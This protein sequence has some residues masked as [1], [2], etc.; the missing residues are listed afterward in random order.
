[1]EATPLMYA[2][3]NITKS[4]KDE[5]DALEMVI[6]LI[7]E[8]NVDVT[9][10]DN[11][12]LNAVHYACMNKVSTLRIIE[13]L[14]YEADS[15]NE[16]SLVTARTNEGYTVLMFAC[17]NELWDDT[18]CD[19]SGVIEMVSKLV[20]QFKVDL[21]A[22]NIYGN[23]CLHYAC[24]NSLS[25]DLIKSLCELEPQIRKE[26]KMDNTIPLLIQRINNKQQSPF[27]ALC[28]SEYRSIKHNISILSFLIKEYP[29][30]IN[31]WKVNG[32]AQLNVEPMNAIQI[33]CASPFGNSKAVMYV[34][35]HSVNKTNAWM[36]TDNNGSTLLMD[37]CLKSFYVSDWIEVMHTLVSHCG[38][39]LVCTTNNNG[40]NVFHCVCAGGSPLMCDALLTAITE[41]GV[42]NTNDTVRFLWNTVG[43]KGNKPVYLLCTRSDLTLDHEKEWCEV[44]HRCVFE[45]GCDVSDWRHPRALEDANQNGYNKLVS[46]MTDT[47]SVDITFNNPRPELINLL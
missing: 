35:N 36:C 15:V 21:Y 11:D 28:A 32:D 47:Q 14:E 27:D 1:M 45:F 6:E 34:L 39:P 20:T 37:V 3:I 29:T 46:F 42:S 43:Q 31:P 44:L 25:L 5:S 26:H 16:T 40:C 17:M 7:D 10:C 18:V 13:E 23:T 33:M 22:S 19:E 12:G 2:C 9:R 8:Y 41:L 30:L 4:K 24:K 38:M